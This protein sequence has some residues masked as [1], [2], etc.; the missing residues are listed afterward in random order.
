[1]AVISN[2][3]YNDDRK[4]FIK[5]IDFGA[6]LDELV[7]FIVT[8]ERTFGGGGMECANIMRN[9]VHEKLSLTPGSRRTIM[10]MGDYPLNYDVTVSSCFTMNNSKW[11]IM[12]EN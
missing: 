6:K 8:V 4:R 3:E 12:K 5:W 2:G 10:H 7:D 1:M 9:V 11:N